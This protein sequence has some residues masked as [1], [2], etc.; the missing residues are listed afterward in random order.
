MN[1]LRSLIPVALVSIFALGVTP[2]LAAGKSPEKFCKQAGGASSKCIDLAEDARDAARDGKSKG[3]K[4]K[5]AKG[6][7]GKFCKANGAKPGSKQYDKC[8]KTAKQAERAA[9]KSGD[10]DGGST[11]PQ[12]AD[13]VDNDGDGMSDFPAD[14]DCSSASDPSEGDLYIPP[15]DYEPSAR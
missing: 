15:D 5:K 9:G 11:T 7:A 13:G 8:L 2:A 14:R 6:A 1:K 4:G 12:C 10:S 3:K